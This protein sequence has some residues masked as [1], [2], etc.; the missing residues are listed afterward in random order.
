MKAAGSDMAVTV[1]MNM[2]DG[3]KGGMEIDESLE[4]ARTLQDECGVHALVLSGGFVS[5]APM[6]VMR[7]TMPIRTLTHYMPW[8]YLPIG[9]RMVGKYMIPSV[10]FKEAYFLEDALKFR[11]LKKEGK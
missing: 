4:V 7:G 8:G 10:P 3:F 1:K 9:V 11:K 2:R 5:R 6:Y